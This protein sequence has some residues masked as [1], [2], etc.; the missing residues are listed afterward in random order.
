MS[1]DRE[2][3]ERDFRRPEFRHAEPTD[4]EFRSDGKVVRKD[5]WESGIRSIVTI[6][7]MPRGDFEIDDVVEHV[8]KLAAKETE[9]E[10]E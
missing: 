8:R 6:L 5:R 1:A 4:Y 9:P 2:V 10:V 3:T 7:G